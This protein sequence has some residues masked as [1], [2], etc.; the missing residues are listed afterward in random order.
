MQPIEPRRDLDRDI[1]HADLILQ[2]Q[3]HRHGGRCIASGIAEIDRM[4]V[5]QAQPRLT[6]QRDRVRHRAGDVGDDPA[7]LVVFHQAGDAHPPAAERQPAGIARRQPL[8]PGLEHDLQRVRI[9]DLELH[10]ALHDRRYG[11]QPVHRYARGLRRPGGAVQGQGA[12]VA[13][14]CHAEREV[15]VARHPGGDVFHDPG[16]RA[17][18]GDRGPQRRQVGEGQLVEIQRQRGLDPALRPMHRPGR[19]D[20]AGRAPLVAEHRHFQG[21]HRDLAGRTAGHQQGASEWHTVRAQSHG[22]GPYLR[23]QPPP[24]RDECGVQIQLGLDGNQRVERGEWRQARSGTG[25]GGRR[26]R[27]QPGA[28]PGLRGAGGKRRAGGQP[29]ALVA[30]RQREISHAVNAAGRP[31]GQVDRRLRCVPGRAELTIGDGHL[32]VTDTHAA[33]LAEQPRQAG[34]IGGRRPRELGEQCCQG[35][36]AAGGAAGRAGGRSRRRN[37]AGAGRRIRR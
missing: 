21:F 15:P 13:G 34:A 7:D 31:P 1:V 37:R 35:G 9:N 22:A 6:E 16:P 26:Y 23:G 24:L 8:T 30:E 10:R 32:G 5:E 4:L 3:G 33:D 11:A 18:G 20:G 14:R 19:L 17:A 27:G 28:K 12:H 25:E 36:Q 29:R 2:R